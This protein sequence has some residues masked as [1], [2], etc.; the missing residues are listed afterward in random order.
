MAGRA[1]V[2]LRLL[3]E[4]AIAMRVNLMA[5]RAREVGPLMLAALP[6]R[7]L[8]RGVA[9]DAG[10]VLCFRRR[11]LRA[12]PD[13]SERSRV[14][15]LRIRDVILALP[16]ARLAIRSSRVGLDAVR[17]SIDRE[18]RHSLGLVVTTR[19]DGVLLENRWHVVRRLRR[20]TG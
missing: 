3:D 14:H 19:A 8:A 4:H 16:V 2:Y 11:A 9:T 18:N 17:S 12:E 10:L 20:R 5:R 7:S 6:M 1:G 13:L 15:A